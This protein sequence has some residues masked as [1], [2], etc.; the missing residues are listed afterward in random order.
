MVWSE[1]EL[2]LISKGISESEQ[3]RIRALSGLDMAALDTTAA[4]SNKKIGRRV[5]PVEDAL[6]HP[7]DD[8]YGYNDDEYCFYSTT[9]V[10]ASNSAFNNYDQMMASKRKSSGTPSATSQCFRRML[11]TILEDAE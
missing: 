7:C 11:S 6:Q 9:T 5:M 10:S 4:S 8:D 1:H 3:D 2:I